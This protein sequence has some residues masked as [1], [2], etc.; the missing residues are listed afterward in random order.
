MLRESRHQLATARHVQ[1]GIGPA[2][3]IRIARLIGI[4]SHLR[5]QRGDFLGYSTLAW[6]KMGGNIAFFVKI[7]R[8]VDANEVH[9]T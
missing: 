5:D 7:A 2:E 8:K 6:R 9:H 1:I 3:Y 4:L